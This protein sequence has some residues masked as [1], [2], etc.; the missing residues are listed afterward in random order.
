MPRPR[1]RSAPRL[2]WHLPNPLAVWQVA[3]ELCKEEEQD[4]VD[5]AAIHRCFVLQCSPNRAEFVPDASQRV[6]RALCHCRGSSR[7]LLHFT[8]CRKLLGDLTSIVSDRKATGRDVATA[9]RGIGELAAPTLKFY[10]QEV[11][12]L[13]L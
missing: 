8:L 13:R 9:V 10:G 6:Y 7:K 4:G 12:P 11:F 1:E 2:P 5:R 3:Q